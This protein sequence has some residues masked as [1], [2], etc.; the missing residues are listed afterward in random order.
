MSAAS[1][2]QELQLAQP[3]RPP[4]TA[5][6]PRP[7]QNTIFAFFAAMFIAILAALARDQLAPRVGGTRELSRL[8][9]LPSLGAVPAPRRSQ[10]DAPKL[11]AGEADDE[12]YDELRAALEYGS[13]PT[14]SMSCS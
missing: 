12:A 13:R 14:R 7:V 5:S 9:G 6:S 11:P 3:A 2:G 4:A 8:T 1:A 10:G